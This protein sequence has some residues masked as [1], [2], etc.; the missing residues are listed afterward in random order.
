MG[1]IEEHDGK[2]YLVFDDYM[3]DKLLFKTEDV[4]GIR[5]L[6]DTKIL[7]DD[8]LLDDVTLKCWDSNY[9]CY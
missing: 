1:K 9:M 8:N 6:E 5:K 2:N 3:L 7:T 4:I